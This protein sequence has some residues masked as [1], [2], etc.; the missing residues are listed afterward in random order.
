MLIL[1]VPFAKWAHLAYRPVVLM[2]MRVKE[3][4]VA[5]YERP[6]VAVAS[7]EPVA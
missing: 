6:Q 1:E 2:L 7:A 3:R 5:E 4:Y